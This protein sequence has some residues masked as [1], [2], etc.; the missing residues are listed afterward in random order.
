VKPTANQCCER[1][2]GDDC[3]EN[4]LTALMPFPHFDR[5]LPIAHF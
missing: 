2:A 1:K 4:T 3:T 5:R